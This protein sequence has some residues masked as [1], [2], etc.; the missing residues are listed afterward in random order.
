MPVS[1][2][3]VCPACGA[4]APDEETLY[5]NRCGTPVG[6]PTGG[7]PNSQPGQPPQGKVVIT[8]QRNAAQQP[9]ADNSWAGPAYPGFAQDPTAG[10][11]DN[12]ISMITDEFSGTAAGRNYL[13][14]PEIARK[15]KYNHLPLVAD[16]LADRNNGGAID[17]SPSKKY[18][19]LPLIADELKVKDNGANADFDDSTPDFFQ[20]SQK[21][22][23]KPQKKWAFNVTRR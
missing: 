10:K 2:L 19:H 6:K 9:V 11:H 21:S 20:P 13:D 8:S 18:A 5:C 22:K 1:R 17:F 15:K 16:E 14:S 23:E 4:E 7:Q 12:N 3:P